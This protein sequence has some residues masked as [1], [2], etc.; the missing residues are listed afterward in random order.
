MGATDQ[1]TFIR[2]L[3]RAW[4]KEQAS[5][6][7]YR[8]LA[9]R[10]S[11]EVRRNV[12]LALAETEQHHG[13]R[14][15]ARLRDAYLEPWGDSAAVRQAYALAQRLGPLAHAFKELRTIGRVPDWVLPQLAAT[16]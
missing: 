16:L 1:S 4:Q 6:R 3:Q 15:A 13:E 10:E 12:L 9:R 5:Q 8:A 14:W 11:N 2:G 7:I